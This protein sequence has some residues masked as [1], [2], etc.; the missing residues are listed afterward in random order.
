MGG[1]QAVAAPSTSRRASHRF[2]W[3]EG[4]PAGADRGA[5][6]FLKAGQRLK[7]A[8]RKWPAAAPAA[9]LPVVD[10]SARP[11]EPHQIRLAPIWDK[12]LQINANGIDGRQS[13]ANRHR[14]VFCETRSGS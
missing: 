13:A 10:A 7:R 14:T 3:T 11:I 5:C 8:L 9:S 2:D 4:R 12:R 6:A 1:G